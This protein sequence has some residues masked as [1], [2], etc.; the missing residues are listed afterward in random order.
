[1]YIQTINCN[2]TKFNGYVKQLVMSLS[3]RGQRTE[4]LLSNLFKG[5]LAA[6]DKKFIKYI[7]H[8]M[9]KYEEGE[10]IEPDKLMQLAN[11]KFR[12]MKEKG[13]LNAPSEEGEKILALQAK[14]QQLKR[15]ESDLREKSRAVHLLS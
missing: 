10:E 2:I 5:Y 15:L 11:N 9:E 8:K 13:T 6:S 3:A 7:G 14:V 12:L 1:M 4:D